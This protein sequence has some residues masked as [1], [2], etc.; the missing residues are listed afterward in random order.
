VTHPFRMWLCLGWAASLSACL[1][2]GSTGS[3]GDGGAAPSP[4]TVAIARDSGVPIS[5]FAFGQNYWDW[6]DWAGDGVS[7]LTG[8]SSLAT[9]LHLNVLRAGGNNNDWS[10]PVFDTGQ[11][12]RFVAYCRAVGAEPILQAPL[13]AN[14]VD[15]G[16]ATAQSA[17][18]MVTY[19]NVTKGYGVK[20]WEIGND[21]DLYATNQP[22]GFP[23]RTAA[24]YCT[25]FA[26]YVT[27]MKAANAAATDGGVS[28]QFLGPELSQ[29]NVAWL[30][31]F[32]DGCKDY[33]D[34]VTVHR[35]PFSGAQTSATSALDDATSFRSAI[36]SVA[37]VVQ[38]H[39]RPGTPFGIT[40]SNIS[41]D[42]TNSAYTATSLQAGPGTFYAALWA[43]DVMGAAL[44]NKLWTFALWNLGDVTASGF[45]S[46][47]VIVDQ[48]PTPAYYAEQMVSASFRGNVLQPIGVPTGFSVYASYDGVE[49][50][51]AILVLNK[52]TTSSTLTVD[53]DAL[54]SRSYDFPSRSLTLLQISDATGAP[55]QVL[56]YTSDMAAAGAPPQAAQ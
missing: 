33:V 37:A 25:Q 17:A 31:A 38:S 41:Y 39:A 15:G 48:Q 51:T 42:Y 43:A 53:V 5:P 35:Y 10:M 13:V 49:G 46:L 45:V 44:E 16:A 6:V 27:A 54:P 56:R 52:T 40:E 14:N 18:D 21:P 7:G 55:T 28:I 23:V 50:S 9:G 24:E 30:A 32:L 1:S 2:E 11:I 20:Y 29:P 4:G 3:G 22:A 19:A 26:A 12:E 34:V 47:G 8:T 36:T